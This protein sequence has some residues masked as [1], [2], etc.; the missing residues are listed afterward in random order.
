[1]KAKSCRGESSL[2]PSVF[3]GSHVPLDGVWCGVTLQLIAN[4]NKNLN[5]CDVHV[6][7]SRE[8]ENDSFERRKVASKIFHVAAS[9]PRI[10]PWSI[11]GS[12]PSIGV[13]TSCVLKDMCAEVVKVVIGIWI[14]EAFT[15][16]IDENAGVRRFD[17]E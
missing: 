8:V 17:L 13:S 9:W 6:V 16:S 10:V 14:V 7:D 4:V 1:M 12:T 15:E 5:T 2:G 3:D 11:T